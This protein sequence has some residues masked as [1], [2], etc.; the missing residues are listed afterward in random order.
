MVGFPYSRT[1]R[2][3]SITLPKIILKLI[4]FNLIFKMYDKPKITGNMPTYGIKGIIEIFA[5]LSKLKRRF[6]VL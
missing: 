2:D 6:G 4:L 3:E 1:I 5:T